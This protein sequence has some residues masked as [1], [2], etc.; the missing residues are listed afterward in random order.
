MTPTRKQL[1]AWADEEITGALAEEIAA[2]VEMGP[3]MQREVEIHRQLKSKL[4]SHF[5]PLLDEPVPDRLS[6][7][8]RSEATVLSLDAARAH[9]EDKRRPM[10]WVWIAG[11]ALAASLAL[12]VFMPRGAQNVS[13]DYAGPQVAQLLD[14]QLAAEQNGQTEARVLLSFRNESEEFCR[15]FTAEQA[16]GIA[17][18]D[19]QGWR[20]AIQG[21]AG[22]RVN[23]EYRPAGAD[24]AAIMEEAQL[25]AV[26][27]ALDAA[28][29]ASAREAGWR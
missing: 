15:A 14:N 9:R 26:G 4:G 8:L 27:P 22:V 6:D 1:A 5:A 3:N 11:P 28:E 25:M 19:E 29:E 17:C 10:R 7:L 2:A 12:A 16:S 20:F 24:M 23:S 21:E 13:A 18:R